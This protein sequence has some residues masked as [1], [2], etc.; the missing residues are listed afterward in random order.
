[1]K[2]REGLINNHSESQSITVTSK[3]S[4]S[5]QS[6]FQTFQNLG[7]YEVNDT[8]FDCLDRFKYFYWFRLF[9]NAKMFIILKQYC[10]CTTEYDFKKSAWNSFN[11]LCSFIQF[12]SLS[13]NKSVNLFIQY[14]CQKKS[15][16]SLPYHQIFFFKYW[17]YNRF[18]KIFGTYPVLNI[19]SQAHN[20]F[21]FGLK[22]YC[23]IHMKFCPS[24]S[25]F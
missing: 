22:H 25:L 13:S 3:I 21:F 16:Y 11:S 8:R 9:S 12:S 5:S 1:M 2:I 10:L 17:K 19:L 15:L 14:N 7:I 4:N 23:K 20:S 18:P 6:I 24:V